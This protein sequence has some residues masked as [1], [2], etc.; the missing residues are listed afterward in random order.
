MDFGK[1]WAFFLNV[2]VKLRESVS[3]F[4]TLDLT[5]MTDINWLYHLLKHFIYWPKLTTALVLA[6]LTEQIVTLWAFLLLINIIEALLTF[7]T[8]DDVYLSLRIHWTVDVFQGTY[9]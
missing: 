3:F 4:L 2:G 8:A 1:F 6:I 9:V 5:F 7:V